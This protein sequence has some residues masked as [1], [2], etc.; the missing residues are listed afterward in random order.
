ML[1]GKPF[2][3]RVTIVIVYMIEMHEVDILE[4]ESHMLSDIYTSVAKYPKVIGCIS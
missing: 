1:F 3:Q 4:V 2:R